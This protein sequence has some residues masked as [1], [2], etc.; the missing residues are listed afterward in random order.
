MP[1]IAAASQPGK[2]YTLGCPSLLSPEVPTSRSGPH[3][4][5]GRSAAVLPRRAW[6]GRAPGSLLRLGARGAGRIHCTF[7]SRLRA[8]ARQPPARK[9]AVK[10]SLLDRTQ[11]FVV[12]RSRRE[13]WVRLGRNAIGDTLDDPGC[14]TSVGWPYLSHFKTPGRS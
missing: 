12:R 13:C 7:G 5:P 11:F 4:F 3:E 6:P 10:C 8:V 9:G 2:H 1:E 14:N